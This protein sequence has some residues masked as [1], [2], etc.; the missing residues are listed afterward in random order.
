MKSASPED[1]ATRLIELANFL[2]SVP[3]KKFNYD[4]FCNGTA[5]ELSDKQCNTAGCALGW[6]CTMPTFEKLGLILNGNN[7]T[8]KHDRNYD[9]YE[10]AALV[11]GLTPEESKYLFL[12]GYQIKG[13][14]R[15]FEDDG[16]NKVSPREVAAHIRKFVQKKFL[17]Q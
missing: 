14:T 12:P 5:H 11:F 15:E 8:L 7:V 9:S 17:G 6:A 16:E 3:R 1:G 10:V 2:D 13:Y 4:M